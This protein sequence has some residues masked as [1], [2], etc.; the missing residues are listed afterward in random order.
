MA[1]HAP[2]NRV[3]L[4]IWAEDT[5]RCVH[6]ISIS[7]L[8]EDVEHVIEEGF[9][10]LTGWAFGMAAVAVVIVIIV[11]GQLAVGVV[12]LTLELALYK[13]R[14]GVCVHL[15]VGALDDL[16]QLTAIQPH[17]PA[18]GAVVDLNVFPL[19]DD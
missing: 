16:V 5:A 17:A 15:S 7:R 3:D 14:L 8:I 6:I 2:T 19:G 12:V 10:A 18:P 4:R 1:R 9:A 13:R 11:V